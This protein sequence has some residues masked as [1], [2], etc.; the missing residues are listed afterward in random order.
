MA[1]ILSC[2][3]RIGKNPMFGRQPGR[4]RDKLSAAARGWDFRERADVGSAGARRSGAGGCHDHG[5]PGLRREWGGGVPHTRWT[6]PA[7]LNALTAQ[8]MEGLIDATA[9]AER[10]EEI[11]CVVMRGAGEHFMAGGGGKSVP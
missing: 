6:R 1:A 3:R 2:K 11:R 7:A 10:E 4:R 5:E 9:R 8:M